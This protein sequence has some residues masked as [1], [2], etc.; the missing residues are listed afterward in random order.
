MEKRKTMLEHT[1]N[2][3]FGLLDSSA[4]FVDRVVEPIII[5]S[6]T[7]VYYWADIVDI[8]DTLVNIVLGLV[9]IF[10]TALKAYDLFWVLI[11]KRSQR[12]AEKREEMKNAD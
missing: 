4:H 10:Y 11:E 6:L 3:F 2:K 5:Y 7:I 12:I 1:L 9:I 8:M